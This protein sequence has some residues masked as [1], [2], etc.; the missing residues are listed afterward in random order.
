[1]IYSSIQR[2]FIDAWQA[3][4]FGIQTFYPDREYAPTGNHARMFFIPADNTVST[5]G[6]TGTNEITGLFQIDVMYKTGR[7]NGE[8]LTKCDEITSAFVSGQ[9]I[10]Y[11]S[12]QVTI[13]GSQMRQPQDENGWLK[14]IITIEFSAFARRTL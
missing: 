10:N 13:W 11:S 1:M 6:G 12:Q 8:I 2:A 5:L 4:D 7:G 3:A 9:R 14:A